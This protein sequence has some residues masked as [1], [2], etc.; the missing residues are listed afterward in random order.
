MGL[1]KTCLFT[2]ISPQ[3]WRDRIDVGPAVTQ[4]S[5]TADFPGKGTAD[6]VGPHGAAA[7]GADHLGRAGYSPVHISDERVTI[8]QTNGHKRAEQ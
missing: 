3:D 2:F 6:N 4:D 8:F 7:P 5:R 1:T